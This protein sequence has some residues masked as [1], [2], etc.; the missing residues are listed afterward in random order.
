MGSFVGLD[1][2]SDGWFV[3][4]PVGLGVGSVGRLVGTDVGILDGENVGSSVGAGE[5]F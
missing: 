3:G 2:R 4:I 5:G 1:V